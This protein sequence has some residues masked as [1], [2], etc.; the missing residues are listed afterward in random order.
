MTVKHAVR[1]ADVVLDIGGFQFGDQWKHNDDGV[2]N[3]KDYLN[4]LH[5]FGAKTI[6]MPQAFGPFKKPGSKKMLQVLN[7]YADVLIARD[8]ISYGFLIDGGLNSNKVFLYPDFTTS[9]KPKETEYSTNYSG[10]VC[11]IP[12]SKIFQKGGIS[13]DDYI[14]AITFVINNVYNK[15][16]EV[17][18]LNHE[19][20]GDYNLCK[21]LAIKTSHIL[22]IVNGL[23]ALET[24][25][26]I[27]ASYL[28][29]SS[30]FHGVA[31]SLSSSVPCLATSWSHK[32]QKLLNEYEQE[33][34][35]L[36]LS[37][38]DKATILIDRMLD[39]GHNAQTRKQLNRMNTVVQE[40][41]R[42]MWDMIWNSIQ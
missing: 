39:A 1:G 5:G 32:Y 28:V 21:E 35:L 2:S 13:K 33:D 12:N 3:W 9:V 4:K 37:D 6:F 15:G 14:D 10:R 23:N 19:G 18:L 38:L 40:K 29:I 34:C 42:K 8:D 11:I 17:V 25:G 16:F 36:D 22:P 7:D 24:K 31:N 27:A 41:N 20:K 26:M 30:R